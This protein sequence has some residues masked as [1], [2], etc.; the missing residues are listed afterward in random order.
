MSLHSRLTLAMQHAGIATQRELA[1]RLS[2]DLT[3]E[4]PPQTV[5]SIT[6]GRSR[7]SIYLLPIATI[8]GVNPGWLQ[9][10]VGEMLDGDR[11]YVAESRSDYHISDP[12]QIVKRI[13]SL[14][15]DKRAAIDAFVDLCE[16]MPARNAEHVVNLLALVGQM[17]ATH[18]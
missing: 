12:E 16:E 7:N 13:A 17:L 3:R 9:S 18:K 8:C 5:Q 15:P 2:R 14:S 10:G 4:I 1:E 11:Y 6:S